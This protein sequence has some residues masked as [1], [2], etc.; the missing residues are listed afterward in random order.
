MQARIRAAVQASAG[1]AQGVGV[2]LETVGAAKLAA[3][4]VVNV[5]AV[6]LG[7]GLGEY[8]AAVVV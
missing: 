5:G 7:G 6:Q 3:S 4:G 2:D 1:V 8:L